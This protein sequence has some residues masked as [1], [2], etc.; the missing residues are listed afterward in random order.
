MN[1]LL[2]LAC[3]AVLVACNNGQSPPPDTAPTPSASAAAS[4]TA[5]DTT[6]S[7]TASAAVTPSA[8]PSATASAAPAPTGPMLFLVATDPTAGAKQPG[9]TKIGC[10]DWLVPRA[11]ALTAT[12]KKGQIVEAITKLLGEMKSKLTVGSV[13]D[14]PDGT[15]TLDLKGTLTFG[16]TCDPPRLI[17]SVEKTAGQFGKVTISVNGQTK[18]WRCAGDES[19]KCK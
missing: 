19:G 17:N 15:F 9:A 4:T 18:T 6:P 16:G 12:D 8:T 14:G 5:A 11:V 1:K 2:S 3:F 13:K 10:D 7:A